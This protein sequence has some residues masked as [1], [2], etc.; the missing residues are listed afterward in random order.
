M[1]VLKL[2]LDHVL[3]SIIHKKVN[4]TEGIFQPLSA[5]SQ[6]QLT[7]NQQQVLQQ[8]TWRQ[9]YQ[10]VML[11]RIQKQHS[12]AEKC[13]QNGELPRLEAAARISC[14]SPERLLITV[15]P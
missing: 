9:N 6:S 15:I 14:R 11:N 3:K 7:A 2:L 1:F 5:D 12:A 13:Y 10:S 4:N 8:V